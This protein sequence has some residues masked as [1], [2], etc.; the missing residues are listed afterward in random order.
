MVRVERVELSSQV[1]K[2]CILAAVLYPQRGGYPQRG[3]ETREAAGTADALV[4][5]KYCKCLNGGRQGAHVE[6]RGLET[7]CAWGGISGSNR[8]PSG[9]QSDALTI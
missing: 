1:W 4:A 2:T 3:C 9:P 7:L 6:S 5:V 8:R